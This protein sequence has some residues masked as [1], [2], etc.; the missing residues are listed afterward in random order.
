MSILFR[1][2]SLFK[3]IHSLCTFI[4][5][6]YILDVLI[7][8][9][10]DFSFILSL[11]VFFSICY[12]FKGVKALVSS[13]EWNVLYFSLKC[14]KLTIKTKQNREYLPKCSWKRKKKKEKRQGNS[15]MYRNLLTYEKQKLVKYRKLNIESSTITVKNYF[16]VFSHRIILP[17]IFSVSREKINHF[18]VCSTISF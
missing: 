8:L 16:M 6:N 3:F 10:T 14:F 13:W 17:F 15:K 11:L 1:F 2:S 4:L 12:F 7:F 5:W 9:L 18:I